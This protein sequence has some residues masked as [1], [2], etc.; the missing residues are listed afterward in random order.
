DLARSAKPAALKEFAE[1]QAFAG[2]ELAAWDVGFYAERL[3]RSRYSVSQEELRPYFQLPRVLE[4]LFGVAERLFDV[5]I[6]ERKG[7]PIWHSDVRFYDIRDAAGQLLGS[8]YLDPYARPNK[9]SGA[10][11]DECIGRRRLPTGSSQP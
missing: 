1:L 10:W 3:Q 8:F 5:R 7:V 9:R 4:G 2:H 6:R 11:M